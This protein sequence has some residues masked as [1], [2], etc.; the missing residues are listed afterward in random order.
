MQPNLLIYTQNPL[1]NIERQ[2]LG[3]SEKILM[4]SE[5]FRTWGKPCTSSQLQS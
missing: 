2:Q 4:V 1:P 3:L 5:N